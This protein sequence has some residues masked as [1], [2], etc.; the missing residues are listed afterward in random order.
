MVFPMG[1]PLRLPPVD[2][3]PVGVM[4]TAAFA[5]TANP[6]SAARGRIVFNVFFV[7]MIFDMVGLVDV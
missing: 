7:F 2:V 6:A 4:I 5:V 1:L 3:A